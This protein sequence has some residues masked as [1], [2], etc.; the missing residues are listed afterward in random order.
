MN[1]KSTMRLGV[2]GLGKMTTA[3]YTRCSSRSD[4]HFQDKLISAILDGFSGHLEKPVK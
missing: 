3:L 4:T 1:H 2:I